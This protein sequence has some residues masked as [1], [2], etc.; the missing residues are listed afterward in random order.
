M[1]FRFVVQFFFKFSHSANEKSNQN[2][3]FHLNK[4]R[5]SLYFPLYIKIE[6][7]YHKETTMLPIVKIISQLNLMERFAIL[8][9]KK[10]SPNRKHS[11]F[12]PRDK[13]EYNS[14]QIENLF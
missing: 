9:F 14:H 2:K 10:T 4:F 11:Q 3:Y 1:R 8:D 7:F 12:S 6:T 13:L 5:K